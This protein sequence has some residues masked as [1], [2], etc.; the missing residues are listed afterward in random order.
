MTGAQ[1]EPLTAEEYAE[2]RGNMHAFAEMQRGEWY[3]REGDAFV[4]IQDKPEGDPEMTTT[5]GMQ[6]RLFA[7]IDT[8]DASIKVLVEALKAAQ[9]HCEELRDAWERGA[10][11]EHDGQGGTRANRNVSV[12]LASRDALATHGQAGGELARLRELVR[13]AEVIIG[14]ELEPAPA[15]EQPHGKLGG[16]ALEVVDWLQ[17]A[18]AALGEKGE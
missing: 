7:T 18:R 13:R 3:R 17:S 1:P 8:R 2:W 16:A 5:I 11:D 15:C 6:L 12:L 4:P 10:L 9:E 14:L